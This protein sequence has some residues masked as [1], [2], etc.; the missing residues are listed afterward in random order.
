[1]NRFV[2]CP[3]CFCHGQSVKSHVVQAEI[4]PRHAI[5]KIPL[6][7]K[8]VAQKM[9]KIPSEICS[10]L[11]AGSRRISPEPAIFKH[12]I[13]S[14]HLA[15]PQNLFPVYI[16]EILCPVKTPAAIKSTAQLTKHSCVYELGKQRND[17]P[18]LL[19][20]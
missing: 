20:D 10:L 12:F 3:S 14:A 7:I 19:K 18:I 11:C 15:Q 5:K 4:P 6:H 13:R 16:F 9:Q 17:F 2:I 1:M 8:E